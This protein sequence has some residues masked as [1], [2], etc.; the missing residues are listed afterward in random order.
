LG[1]AIPV[2]LQK[3]NKA[4]IQQALDDL[5]KRKQRDRKKRLALLGDSNESSVKQSRNAKTKHSTGKREK[6]LAV[7]SF[8]EHEE[9]AV[10]EIVMELDQIQLD[11]G[12]PRNTEQSGWGLN[13]DA[14]SA[15]SSVITTRLK[16]RQSNVSG[17][18]R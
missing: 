4:Y 7:A 17:P 1:S 15:G 8:S 11:G 6:L 10:S 14:S 5:Q 16:P 3:A 9:D 18:T 2:S 13:G 12:K